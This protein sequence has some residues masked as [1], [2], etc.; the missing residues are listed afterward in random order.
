MIEKIFELARSKPDKVAL[1]YRDHRISYGELAFWISYAREFLARQDLRAGSLA[2]FVRVPN[3]L[4]CWALRFALRSLGLT[5]VDVPAPEALDGLQFRNVGCVITTIPDRP[6]PIAPVDGGY[7]L[8]RIPNP[9]F[10]G[11]KAEGVPKLPPPTGP[12]GGHILL[13]SGTTGVKKKV[14]RIAEHEPP[15]LRRGCELYWISENSI[16]HTLDYAPWT[17]AGYG[18]PLCAWSAGGAVVS[19]PGKDLYRSFQIDGITHAFFIPMKLEEVLAAPEGQLPFSPNL[20]VFVGGAALTAGLTAATKARLTPNVYHTVGSTEGGALGLTRVEQPEDLQS[21]IIVPGADV[22]IV[23]E[24]HRPLPAGQVGMIRVRPV[25]GLTGYLDDEATSR[26][27]FRDGYFYPGDLGQILPDGRLEML[28]RAANVIN[29]GGEKRAVEAIEQQMQDR[30]GADDF[31]LLALRDPSMEEELHILIQARRTI[32]QSEV[33]D[34]LVRVAAL[35]SA[36]K[37]QIHAVDAIPRNEM[38]KI[39]R[40]SARKKISGLLEN[41]PAA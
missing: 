3:V 7:K 10:F 11:K 27:Y 21:H 28:G 4:D 34:A 9:M 20:A 18:L 30:L 24:T 14:L 37:A 1:Y 38:G 32:G 2:V 19:H 16:V 15:E 13:T 17:A 5:T 25:Q 22:Q 12:V 23:D 29:L 41:K 39:D 8:I 26:S 35:T 6:I 40:M 36:P 31:C 33:M